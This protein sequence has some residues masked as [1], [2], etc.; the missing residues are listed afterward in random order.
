M[1]EQEKFERT[2]AE[3]VAY[4]SKDEAKRAKHLRMKTRGRKVSVYQCPY[5]SCWHMTSQIEAD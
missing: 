1:N 4:L 2:C 3:K 5:C